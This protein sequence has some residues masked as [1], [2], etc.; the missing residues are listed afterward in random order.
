[1]TMLVAAFETGAGRA[2]Q[3]RSRNEHRRTLPR[4]ILK[5]APRHGGNRH[6]RMLLFEPRILRTAVADDVAQPQSGPD[7]RTCDVT[8]MAQI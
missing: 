2:E 5:R 3:H 6:C 7:A 1:M 4:S 8:A